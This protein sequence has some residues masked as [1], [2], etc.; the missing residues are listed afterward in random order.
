MLDPKTYLKHE[1]ILVLATMNHLLIVTFMVEPSVLSTILGFL[2]G[3]VNLAFLIHY[4]TLA[5]RMYSHYRAQ[6]EYRNHPMLLLNLIFGVLF[7]G[8]FMYLLFVL[9]FNYILSFGGLFTG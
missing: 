2:L 1:I 8:A 9:L 4:F 5:I 6:E 3:I 7:N